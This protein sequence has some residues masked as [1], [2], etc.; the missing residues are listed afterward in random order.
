MTR[1]DKGNDFPVLRNSRSRYIERN[2]NDD[3]RYSFKFL[4]SGMFVIE[5][6]NHVIMAVLLEIC[7]FHLRLTLLYH[8]IIL[9]SVRERY[10]NRQDS[11][12]GLFC[13]PCIFGRCSSFGNCKIMPMEQTQTKA[14]NTKRLASSSP[15]K[16]NK[17]AKDALCKTCFKPAMDDIL[18]CIWCEIL[19]HSVKC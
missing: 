12:A 9:P 18:E 2:D 4:W 6:I 10:Y 7:A 16:D 3:I 15:E 13:F 8:G 14:G 11:V 19:R 1:R 17:I 5:V